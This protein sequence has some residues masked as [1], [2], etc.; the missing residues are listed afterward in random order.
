M[1][2]QVTDW[3]E[4]ETIQIYLIATLVAVCLMNQGAGPDFPE[5]F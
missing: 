4:N 5:V 1:T 3:P 2:E